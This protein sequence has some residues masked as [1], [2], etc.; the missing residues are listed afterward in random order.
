METKY[1]QHIERHNN[2]EVDGILNGKVYL[3]TKLDG[4]NIGIHLE[5]GHR[6]S[7]CRWSLLHYYIW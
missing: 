1:Y 3:F 2:D 4:T 6:S 5:D 7:R